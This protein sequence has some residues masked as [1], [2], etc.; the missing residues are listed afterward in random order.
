MASG[1]ASGHLQDTL[2]SGAQ[3]SPSGSLAAEDAP[4]SSGASA[5]A[6]AQGEEPDWGFTDDELRTCV[7][8]FE[9]LRDNPDFFL[10]SEKLRATGLHWMIN[11]GQLYKRKHGE[12]FAKLEKMSAS[13][14]KKAKAASDQ[15]KMA[16][17]QMRK[18]RE[19][20]MKRLL[21][22]GEGHDVT[23]VICAPPAPEVPCI[24]GPA[25]P[26]P[27]E[28]ATPSSTAASASDASAA[29]PIPA[30]DVAMVTAP[31]L[32]GSELNRL[33]KCHV[34][35]MAYNELHHFYCS[36]CPPCGALNFA[37][38]HQTADLRGRNVLLTGSRIKIGQQICLSLLRAGA[39]VIATTR[40]PVDMRQRYAEQP[41]FAE[42][43]DRLH[44]YR[45]DL[46]NLG[47]VTQFCAHLRRRYTHL[48]AIVNNAAQTVARPPS[49]YANLVHK[50]LL[51]AGA[52]AEPAAVCDVP[53]AG[54][55]EPEWDAFC[56]QEA[57]IAYSSTAVLPPDAGGRA[58]AGAQS[59]AE[60][61]GHAHAAAEVAGAG[62]GASLSTVPGAAAEKDWFDMY[63]TRQ[64]ALDKRTFNSWTQ[65]LGEITGEEAA[66]VHA[67][68]ALAPFII[69]SQ[70]KPLL[71]A[72][73]PGETEATRRRY[74]INVSAMEGQFYRFKSAKHPHTNMAKAS[75][76]M[77]TRTAAQGYAKARI[78]M[79]AVDTGWITDE[80]PHDKASERWAKGLTCPLDE[81]DAA[82]RVLDLI[83]IQSEEYGKFWKDFREIP[84]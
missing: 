48:Y 46:R 47:L 1:E 58:V 16:K 3:S 62:G 37:K 59:A 44:V 25:S 32:Q 27:S 67:I 21:E 66:E 7:R 68:N 28:A 82:A 8:V 33:R 73:G 61:P 51:V 64:T 34:C 23:G 57:G 24:A 20:A 72:L 22:E 15:A 56:R 10:R 70:L 31:N 39:T 53:G 74:V 71:L 12:T 60:A 49:Y 36:L 45:V 78:Y 14:R 52:G 35:K 65:E 5:A 17:T 41:D 2:P 13:D 76:N 26:P 55:V 11:R 30:L 83:Y 80:N 63:D 29:E 9:R 18:D 40:F 4:A 81:I 50:E 54:L 38:R 42:W 6:A 69:N 77:M 79:N 43:Q 84:W 75:L 19:Q